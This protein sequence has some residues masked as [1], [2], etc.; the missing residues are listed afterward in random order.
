M[1]NQTLYMLDHGSPNT[2]DGP[3]ILGA[4]FLI[5][6]Q[7]IQGDVEFHVHERDW[8]SHGHHKDSRYD[9]VVL[10]V[11][12]K[13]GNEGA[14]TSSNSPIWSVKISPDQFLIS[15]ERRCQLSEQND[16]K[17]I[18]RFLQPLARI[19]WLKK[20]LQMRDIIRETENIQD[21]FYIKSFRSLGLKGNEHLFE[22]LARSVPLHTF[23]KLKRREKI[24]IIL[25]G[26]AGFLN[27][28]PKQQD[29]GESDKYQ[30]WKYLSQKHKIEQLFP[31]EAWRKKGIRPNAFPERRIQFGADIVMALVSGWQPWDSSFKETLDNIHHFFPGF[32]PAKG[33]RVE[34][35]GNVVLPFQE[36]WNEYH[37]SGSQE[38]KFLYWFDLNI[39]YSYGQIT[40][41]FGSFFK[42][43]HRSNFGIQQGLLSLHE[44]YCNIDLCQLCPLRR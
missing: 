4:S 24:L 20:V 40:D 34:W 39:G 32:H 26:A 25:L 10:H 22:L 3:D 1:D 19:R 21:A 28:E 17:T 30:L 44:R 35:L 23:S 27:S 29:K 37:F 12:V 9:H 42:H 7:F 13:S 8:F 36:A 15:R 14:I 5:G 31:Q 43:K 16:E 11:V 38:N 33:W 2:Y 6:T 18:L 41:L